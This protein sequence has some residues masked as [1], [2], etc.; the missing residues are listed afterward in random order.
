MKASK[1][2]RKTVDGKLY[3]HVHKKS[4]KTQNKDGNNRRSLWQGELNHLLAFALC[5]IVPCLEQQDG[6]LK[7]LLKNKS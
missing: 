4:K 2:V 3:K 5:K 7:Y 6:F 1:V